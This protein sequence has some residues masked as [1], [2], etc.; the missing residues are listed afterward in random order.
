[1][2]KSFVSGQKIL[3]TGTLNKLGTAEAKESYFISLKIQFKIARGRKNK[4]GGCKE[5][6]ERGSSRLESWP[7]RPEGVAVVVPGSQ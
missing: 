2:L 5:D 4:R 6:G 3:R 7:G 1:M